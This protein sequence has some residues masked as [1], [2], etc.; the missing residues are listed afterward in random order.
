MNQFD[1]SAQIV[2]IQDESIIND[3]N[4]TYTCGQDSAEEFLS[5]KCS[6]EELVF[7]KLKYPEIKTYSE[8][9]QTPELG[10]QFSVAIDNRWPE[11]EPY[12]MKSPAWWIA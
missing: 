1:T 5:I 12:I 10:Y 7:L 8:Y 6:K 3:I 9:I 4:L 11:A 2:Y